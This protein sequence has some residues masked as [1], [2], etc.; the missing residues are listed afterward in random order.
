[1]AIKRYSTSDTGLLNPSGLVTW[2]NENKTGTILLNDM[3]PI[4]NQKANSWQKFKHW[5]KDV[6]IKSS[7]EVIG[8]KAINYR[9]CCQAANIGVSLALLGL[10]IPIFTRRNTK[11]KH[12]KALK[13]AQEQN[14]LSPENNKKDD[15][16]V[17]PLNVKY[18]KLTAGFRAEKTRKTA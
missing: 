15:E 16:H 5:M 18:S 6:N 7:E 11:K 1:M 13:L 9:S 14:L 2:L 4:D 8:K 3:K 12:E 10:I 17:T